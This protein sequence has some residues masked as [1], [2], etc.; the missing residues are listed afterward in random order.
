M[1]LGE[2]LVPN[3]AMDYYDPLRAELNLETPVPHVRRS[4]SG[5]FPGGLA[6]GVRLG[7][8][9]VDVECLAGVVGV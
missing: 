1:T 4:G 8:S 7:G 3:S 2:S 5:A 9:E 6:D